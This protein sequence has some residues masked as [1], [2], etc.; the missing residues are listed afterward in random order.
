MPAR[1]FL[2]PV[3]A[4]KSDPEPPEDASVVQRLAGLKRDGG[5]VL[6]VG[7]TRRAHEDLC[8]RFLG[9]A[10][11]SVVVCT[12]GDVAEKCHD[13]DDA[14]V[15]E[16]PVA[17]RSSAA[18]TPTDTPDLRSVAADLESAL[19]STSDGPPTQVCFDSLLPFV[20][21]TDRTTL[22]SVLTSI[23]DTAV[24][25]GSIV[26][27]HLPAFPESVPDALYPRAD[28]VVEVQSQRE[29]S[30]QRWYLPDRGPATGWV[31]V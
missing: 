27:L 9:S 11:R 16:R 2:S 5:S 8:E 25:T 14:R 1:P 6:V 4:M 12:D 29:R 15:I 20:D 10:G 17:T 30:Y 24:E 21:V 18:T 19:E 23:R 3:R 13:R 7:A 26:H 22:V 28:A 31:P